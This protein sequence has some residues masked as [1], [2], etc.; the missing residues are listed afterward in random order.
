MRAGGVGS[1]ESEATAP[2]AMLRKSFPVSL[3]VT[4]VRGPQP[5][6]HSGSAWP[7]V[8]GPQPCKHSGS[9]RERGGGGGARRGR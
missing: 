6:K 5:C 2:E 4:S 9:A 8:R 3:L 7:S 1:L